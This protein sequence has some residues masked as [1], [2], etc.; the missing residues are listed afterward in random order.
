MDRMD[1]DATV[2]HPLPPPEISIVVPAYNEEENLVPLAA[3]IAE[4]FAVLGLTYELIFVDDGSQDNTAHVLRELTAEHPQ[5]R[6]IR[7]QQNAGQSAALDA[8]FK[9]AR[10]PVVV[11]LDAD[12]QN[13]PGDIPRFLE[14]L[15]DYDVVC[16]MRQGR[17]DTW[18][19][20]LSSRCANGV[21]R[22]VLH[23]NIVDIGCSLRAYRGHC[24]A[25]IK[26]YNGMHRFLPVLLQI[27]GFHVG[28]LPVRH[29]P[30]QHGQSKYNM[31]N[32]AWRALMDLLAVRWMQSRQLRYDIIGSETGAI[33]ARDKPC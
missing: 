31:R 24:L 17:Q 19:R 4:T 16:G 7:F 23:D 20:R 5:V 14:M 3:A 10:G 1:W 11:T 33:G 13:D 28:Q 2:V 8:G 27:E 32:R 29:H 6:S 21:R 22:C 18:L 25:S 15:K 9:Q 30:R 26:L 12:L